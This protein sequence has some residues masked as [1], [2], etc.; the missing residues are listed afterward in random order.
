MEDSYLS[1]EQIKD[2]WP[3]IQAEV[4]IQWLWDLN[5]GLSEPFGWSKV[6]FL[7]NKV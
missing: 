3:W 1:G 7:T 6:Y 4:L 5:P 2:R